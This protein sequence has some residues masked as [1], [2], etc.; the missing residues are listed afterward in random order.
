M[1]RFDDVMVSIFDIPVLISP[2]GG[3]GDDHDSWDTNLRMTPPTDAPQARSRRRTVRRS[4]LRSRR[5]LALAVGLSAAAAAVPVAFGAS[6][7][8]LAEVPGDHHSPRVAGYATVALEVLRQYEAT[9]NP[10]AGMQ[11]RAALQA[12]AEATA[13]EMGTSAVAMARAWTS[14][15]VEHQTAVLAALSQLGVAYHSD[16]SQPGV[17][18]RLLRTDHVRLG[19][20][21]RE[22]APPERRADRLRRRA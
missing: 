4:A 1:L 16:S 11:Y 22:P 2:N 7:T 12:T 21:R 14:V 3:G 5:A 9:H 19:R 13:D 6:G 10:I 18:L 15:D 8:A 20:S 17:G